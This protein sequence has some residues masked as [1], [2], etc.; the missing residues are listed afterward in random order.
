[1]SRGLFNLY[2]VKVVQVVPAP[3]YGVDVEVE[4]LIAQDLEYSEALQ[5]AGDQRLNHGKTVR[6][7]EQT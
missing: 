2:E 3:S 6:I 5:E 1:M 7:R 4:R